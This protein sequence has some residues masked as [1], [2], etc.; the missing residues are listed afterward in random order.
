MEWRALWNIPWVDP[1]S[2]A[3][4]RKPLSL[5]PSAVAPGSH[6]GDEIEV[7]F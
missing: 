4:V 5:G 6:Y 2:T 3:L 1:P 7:R